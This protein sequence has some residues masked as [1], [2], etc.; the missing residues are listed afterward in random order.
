MRK[1]Y[2]LL[3]STMTVVFLATTV[4]ASPPGTTIEYQPMTSQGLAAGYPF[5][6]WVV[7]DKSSNPAEPGYALLAGATIRF[8]FP[9]A[10]TPKLGINPEAVLLYDWPQKA[11]PVP[12]AVGLDPTDSHVLSFSS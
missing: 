12:F 3:F 8:T 2:I 11:A 5:E 1:I 4:M 6:A 9:P 10:F 7:F